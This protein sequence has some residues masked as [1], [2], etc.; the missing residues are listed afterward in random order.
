MRIETEFNK[1]TWYS[2]LLALVI[3]ITLPFVGFYL[4]VKYEELKNSVRVND[5]ASS[6]FL[7]ENYNTLSRKTL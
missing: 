3:F 5:A 4:G 2:K 6:V 1:V 7:N